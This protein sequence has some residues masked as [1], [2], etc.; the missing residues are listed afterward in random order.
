MKF[1][2][3]ADVFSTCTMPQS[4]LSFYIAKISSVDFGAFDFSQ[5]DAFFDRTMT[6]NFDAA[7]Q[8]CFNFFFKKLIGSTLTIPALWICHGLSLIL[9]SS[10]GCCRDVP[11]N[12]KA[13]DGSQGQC[14]LGRWHHALR[15][16]LPR[17]Q[18]VQRNH[19][20]GDQGRPRPGGGTQ[21]AQQTL[22]RGQVDLSSSLRSLT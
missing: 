21:R 7:C 13:S 5:L 22:K 14:L 4:L 10:S 15:D 19:S 17:Q 8:L 11:A 6:V 2:F 3:C 1:T 9:F 16:K 20:W 12:G 18:Q